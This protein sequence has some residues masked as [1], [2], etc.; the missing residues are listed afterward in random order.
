MW[1]PP[2]PPKV[3]PG[4]F[5][6]VRLVLG[7]KRGLTFGGRLTFWVHPLCCHFTFPDTEN[8][9]VHAFRRRATDVPEEAPI[10]LPSFKAKEKSITSWFKSQ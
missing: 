7:P 5:L 3:R 6:S 10:R 2:P 8:V 4:V 9:S 1:I